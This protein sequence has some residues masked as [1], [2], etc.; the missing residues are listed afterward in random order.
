MPRY[1]FHINDGKDIPDTEGVEL[2][3]LAEAREQAITSA[4]EMIRHT[5]SV[6]WSGAEWSMHVTDE[7]GRS[8]FTL[9]FAADEEA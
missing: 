1:F 4:G 3:G 9:R 2:P 6:V 7:A 8:V 5:G